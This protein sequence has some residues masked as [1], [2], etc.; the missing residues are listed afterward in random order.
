MDF[1]VHNYLEPQYL[2]CVAQTARNKSDSCNCTK[3]TKET[4]RPTIKIKKKAETIAGGEN[5]METELQ[6]LW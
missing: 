1:I 6:M 4:K 3:E 5:H 2:Y